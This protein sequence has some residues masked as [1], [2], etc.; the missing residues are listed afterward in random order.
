MPL[1]PWLLAANVASATAQIPTTD[2][3]DKSEDPKESADQRAALSAHEEKLSEKLRSVEERIDRMELQMPDEDLSPYQ[4]VVQPIAPNILNPSITVIGDLLYRY[5][6]RAVGEEGER[7]DNTVNL[8]EVEFDFRAAVDP[9]ANAVVIFAIA[10]EVP[11]EFEA[12]IEEAYVTIGRLPLPFLDTPP[13]SLQFKL[14]R[15]RTN[16]GLVNRLHLHDLPWVN[17]P[18]VMQE[19]FGNEGYRGT[20]ASM[21]LLLPWFDDEGAVEFSAQVL[22]GGGIPVG[23]TEARFPSAVGNL[24]L[25]QLI[26]GAHELNLAGIFLFARTDPDGNL[27]DFNYAADALY[28][29]QPKSG[30]D[31]S[32]FLLGGEAFFSHRQFV[33]EPDDPNAPPDTVLND[34]IGYFA[35]AQVQLSRRTYLGARWD[36]TAALTDA[37]LRARAVS[38]YLTWYAS[39]FLRFRFGYEHGFG[40]AE[41]AE[42]NTAFAQLDFVF[43][44]HP[45]EPYWVNP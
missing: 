5:D 6:S 42:R 3:P 44:S 22:A 29:W 17:R 9:Y 13:L 43:G 24:R 10:S 41:L 27:N 33:A 12:E 40:N 16:V 32:S 45:P 21:R 26:A 19:L 30:S 14:G 25:V 8:R 36:D 20:G 37:S 31:T 2:P 11:G 39:E 28:K 38:G 15:F 1:Y 7:V 18:L 35:Y 23:E 34:P 4:T